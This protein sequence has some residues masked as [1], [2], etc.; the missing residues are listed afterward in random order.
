MNTGYNLP[1]PLPSPPVILPSLQG[2]RAS[3]IEYFHSRLKVFKEYLAGDI[4]NINKNLYYHDVLLF[5]QQVK[6]ITSIKQIENLSVC[7]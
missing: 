6:H 4:V 2:F 1:L 5:I 3:D 7:L